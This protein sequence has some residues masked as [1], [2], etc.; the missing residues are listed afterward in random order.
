MNQ[1]ELSQLAAEI[2][3]H[4]PRQ[5]PLSVMLWDSELIGQYLN[6]SH[7]HVMERVVIQPTFPAAIRMPKAQPLWKAIEVIN[8]VEKFKEH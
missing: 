5:L 8:W 6:R 2:A 7:R 1:T 4:L 3:Q